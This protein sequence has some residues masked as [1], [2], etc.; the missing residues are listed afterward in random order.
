[1]VHQSTIVAL[2]AALAGQASANPIGAQT[3]AA[4]KSFTV[5]QVA[6]P[7]FKPVGPLQLAKTY[8]KY[9]IKMPDELAKT[10][11]KYWRSEM[12]KR[13]RGNGS[14]PAVPE[15][16]DIEYLSP[17][18]LG[19]PPQTLHLDFDTGSADLWVFCTETPSSSVN[20]QTL[21]DPKRSSTAT[22]VA[23]ATWSISYGDGS[24]SS[25][26]VYHDVV[27]VGGVGFK[28]QGV[29]CATSVSD[30]FT[31]DAAND[32]LLGLAFPNLNTVSPV[33][34]P[35]FYTNVVGHLDR[36]VF[37]AD[38]KYHA[39][40]TYDFGIINPSKYTGSISYVKVD[41]SL[42]YWVHDA[43]VNGQSVTGIADTGTT[44]LLLPSAIVDN[45]YGK[46]NGSKL[47]PSQGGYVF[48]CNAKLPDLTFSPGNVKITVPGKYL[49]Y[50]PI[51]ARAS[52]CF[53]GLQ[54]GTI[55]PY[56]WAIFGDIVL[57]AAFVV[58]E[59]D[60]TGNARIGW[61]SKHL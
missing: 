45:Y 40:G 39:A 14:T 29:E 18:K 53:G 32:G 47:D 55:P 49:N 8:N 35:T 5:Q 28:S 11:S 56:G 9:G 60:S 38:L 44:L 61:A 1:M 13:F 58:F 7:S 42:G 19:T 23:N 26:D 30:Q 52:A 36:P 2:T 33:Q 16:Y 31:R 34:E 59:A 24:S 20:G 25:G 10:V 21:Y 3:G 50:A 17:V 37:T 54:P 6:N 12:A 46:V 43:R 51:D 15:M 41:G 4:A 27:N 48:P 22:R 57:K